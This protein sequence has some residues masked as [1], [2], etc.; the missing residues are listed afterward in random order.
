MLI[1]TQIK[2]IAK[3][4]MPWWSMSSTMPK[5]FQLSSRLQMAPKLRFLSQLRQ[6]NQPWS[7][8]KKRLWRK[9]RQGSPLFKKSLASKAKVYLKQLWRAVQCDAT[10][11]SWWAWWRAITARQ[12]SEL[13][14]C[15]HILKSRMRT[16]TRVCGRNENQLLKF[17]LWNSSVWIALLISPTH[18]NCLRLRAWHTVLVKWTTE[19]SNSLGSSSSQYGSSSS[20]KQCS[21]YSRPPP[22]SSWT[23]A[24][25]EFSTTS[26]FTWK[27]RQRLTRISVKKPMPSS[28]SS[29]VTWMELPPSAQSS[30]RRRIKLWACSRPLCKT[31]L[32]TLSTTPA[33]TT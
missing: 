18:R 16:C 20:A 12:G 2:T 13:L 6:H 30:S 31:R 25:R 19:I 3:Y 24:P 14:Y 11:S 10:T 7:L 29:T 22:W 28:A 9:P 15:N 17:W 1:G 23:W 5:V 21:F 27:I 33:M 8:C 4:K 32:T 26:T